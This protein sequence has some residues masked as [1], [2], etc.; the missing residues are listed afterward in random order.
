MNEYKDK[1]IFVAGGTGGVG[2]GIVKHFVDQGS[3][4]IVSSRSESQLNHLRKHLEDKADQLTGIVGNIGDDEEAIKIAQ[5]VKDQFEQLDGVVASLG[6]WWQG[7]YLLDVSIEEWN[8]LIHNF[9][10]TQFIASKHLIPLVKKGG[11]Y[12]FISGFS[13]K[14]GYPNAGPVAVGAAG[15]LMLSKVYKQEIDPKTLRVNDLILGPINTRKRSIQ[16][17]SPNYL[18]SLEVGRFAGFIA[19]EENGQNVASQAIEL[20]KKGDV[21]EKIE[22]FSSK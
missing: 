10:T 11:S 20:Y 8:E 22:F 3:K 4:V 1:V 16:Y 13:A 15:A 5:Q 2:E 6:G 9:L 21:E 7:K 18:S 19:F 12:S 14:D 17:Q